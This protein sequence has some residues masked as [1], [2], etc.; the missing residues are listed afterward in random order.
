MSHRFMVL[1][2]LSL[3]VSAC[4]V[5]SEEE[6]VGEIS[7]ELDNRPPTGDGSA[8]H[9]PERGVVLGSREGMWCCGYR[10]CNEDDCGNEQGTYIRSCAACDFFE[11]VPGDGTE[12]SGT[13]S[14]STGGGPRIPRWTPPPGGGVYAP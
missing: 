1:A 11:C 14:S 8:C 6:E 5:S 9:V 7:S 13:T 12:D 4:F 10:I 2:W 3:A